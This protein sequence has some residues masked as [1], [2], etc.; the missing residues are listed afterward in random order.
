[1]HSCKYPHLFSPII[2]A[3]TYFKN[4]IFASPQGSSHST[5]GNQPTDQTIAFYERK[6]MGG[7]AA[8][9]VGDAVVDSYYGLGNGPH[10]H[11]DDFQNMV[12]LNRLARDVNRHGC[13]SS[14][15]L[16]HCGS[17]SRVSFDMGHP[18]YGAIAKRTENFHHDGGVFAEEMP[19]DIIIRT[20]DKFADAAYMAKR[21]GFGMVTLHG[22]HGW[23]LTQ[24]MH[25]TNNRKDKWGG[26]MENRMRFPIAVCDAIRKKCGN[27]F[28]IEM[29]MSGSEVYD[30]GYDLDYGVEIAKHLD[31]HLDLIHVSA[32]CHEVEEV[33]TV[34]HPS[35]FLEDGVNVKYAAEIKKHVKTAV[36]TVGSLSNPEMMEEIIASGK[37]DVVELA[38]GL[39]ADPDLPN[40]AR[41]GRDD[42]ITEC[43]R[44]FACFSG[45]LSGQ[46]YSCAVNPKIGHVLDEKYEQLPTNK[47]KIL[48]VGGGIGGMTAAL[49]AAEQGHEVILC[50]K[51]DKLGGVLRCEEKVPFK[52]HL[53]EYL[54]SQAL[55]VSRAAIDVRLNTEVTPEYAES[56]G[57]DA[58]IAAMGARPFV[59]P[60]PGVDGKNVIS[61]EEVYM[62][63]EKAGDR[64]VILGGGLVGTEMSVYLGMMGK[65]CTVLEMAPKLTYGG[66]LLQGQA[67]ELQYP[68]YGIEICTSTRAVEVNEQ[69]VVAETPEGTKL[70]EADTVITA[71]GM[72]PLMNE[73]LE[74]RLCAPDFYLTGDCRAAK[75]IKEANWDAYHAA[76]DAGRV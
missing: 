61:A 64:V 28:V 60:I 27:N 40:K 31:G 72:K 9:C 7:A 4:R 66:N 1:M 19:E 39:L 69:G 76:I 10:I 25:P 36:A 73:A 26:S 43:L 33:F 21:C 53:E 63:P 59:A 54:D 20:I 44:C 67:L 35:M 15:E 12:H 23:L 50:E 58:I 51:S 49:T 6:A 57:A 46:E 37:A 70:F 75:S 29:R 68:K 45:L 47:K 8:V 3:N 38:R 11:M 62:N 42:E 24:F 18:I 65:K 13:V 2:L 55:K 32:G 22:G 17:S 56:V 14:I 52:K 48:V 74:L 71:M 5:Y 34:T 16:N 41:L 30:G